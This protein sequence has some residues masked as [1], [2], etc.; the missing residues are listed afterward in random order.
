MA[1]SIQISVDLK[2]EL[3][4]RK[5]YDKETYEEVIWDLIED[6]LELSEE[7]LRD[8]KKA[9]ADVKAGRVYSLEEVKKELGL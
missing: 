9:E 6:T 3:Q 8:I 5:F 4:K 1:T 2:E 7:T